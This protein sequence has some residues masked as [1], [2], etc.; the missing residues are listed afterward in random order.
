MTLKIEKCRLSGEVSAPPSKSDAHRVL[1]CSALSKA[2]TVTNLADSEDINATLGCLKTLG[3]KT[4]TT[5][6]GVKIGGINPF[7]ISENLILDCNE[8][9]STLRFLI[10]LCLL[11]GKKITFKGKGRL[12]E[13]PLTVYEEICKER[14]IAFEKNGDALGLCGKLSSGVFSVDGGVSSQFISG[15][16]YALP[17]LSG[18]SEIKIEG[19]L[20]SKPYI[21]MTVETLSRFGV[22]IKETDYGYFV[23]G[24]QKY[25]S[26]NITVEGDWSNAAF[27]DGFNLLG[28]SVKVM[29]LNE[30]SLQGD[31]IYKKMYEDLKSGVKSFDLR[32]CPDLAPV[33]FALAGALGGAEFTGTARLKIKESDRAEAMK[34]ELSKFGINVTVKE[35]RVLVSGGTLKTPT[36]KLKGHNDHRIVMALTLLCTLTGGE[37]EG[38]EA[39]NKSFPDFFSKI[40]ALGFVSNE[41]R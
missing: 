39:V 24:N 31:K 1:I 34:E 25:N 15:L 36:K 6:N 10:P 13:R 2:S 14:G 23:K 35:N 30:N 27:L 3:A 19:K 28:G 38:C 7:D 16:L 37:I 26:Q 22:E 9:G 11:S 41:I 17:L 21:D 4:E 20:E 33:M 18:D 40:S 32:D 5:E 12:M 29:G 8:S